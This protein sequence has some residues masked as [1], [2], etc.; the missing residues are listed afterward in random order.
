MDL[1]TIPYN[2]RALCME[3]RSNMPPELLN[4]TAL[5]KE[6]M[7]ISRILILFLLIAF[8]LPVFGQGHEDRLAQL[9]VQHYR[10]EITL[11][12]QTNIIQGLAHISIKFKQATTEFE[13]DL[14]GENADAAGMKVESVM[15]NGKE[16]KFTHDGEKLKITLSGEAKAGSQKRISIKYSGEPIDG[17]VISKNKFG[18][19]TFFGDNW[20]NRAHHWLPSVDHPS[21]KATV[22]FVVTAPTHYLVVANGKKIEESFGGKGLRLTHWKSMVPLPTKVMVIGAADFATQYSG[23]AAG[24][25]VSAWVYPENKADG[26]DDYKMAVPILKYYAGYFGPYPYAKLAN[27]QS[28]TR[29]GGMENASCIFYHE[30]SVD[31]KRGSEGLIAHEIVHQWFGNSASEANWHHVWLSEGFATYFTN[32]YFQETQGEDEFRKRME[33]DRK[34]VVTFPATKT[35]PVVDPSIEDLN[36]LLSPNSY[37]KGGW[38]LHMLRHKIGDEKFKDGIREYYN[39]FKLSN[40][41]TGDFQKVM[42]KAAGYSLSIFF[43]QWIYRAG[44]PEIKGTWSTKKGKVKLTIQQVQK[45]DA[46]KVP[47]EVAFLVPGAKAPYVKTINLEEKEHEFTFELNA[48]PTQVILDPDVK[49]LF[50]GG[51]TQK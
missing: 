31:G 15:E 7:R 35:S 27:V 48:D 21:D 8:S 42:E 40:A 6:N 5:M 43:R 45:G 36:A 38:V 30:G 50:E 12:D 28:K 20:P 1:S 33:A 47:L 11:S 39:Q 22:E 4:F 44:H 34:K 51:L 14:A 46:F 25:E 29:Y 18:S 41:M 24:V 32:V 17:L 23:D 9:D 37:Q 26:F 49:L 2:R 16:I 10:F 13:L 19:R 3:N